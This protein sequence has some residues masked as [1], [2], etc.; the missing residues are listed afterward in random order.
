[1]LRDGLSGS[2]GKQTERRRSLFSSRGPLVLTRCVF[3]FL[4][5]YNECSYMFGCGLVLVTSVHSALT[6]NDDN[7]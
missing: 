6:N 7:Q 4:H 3:S 1:M 2:G 5:R